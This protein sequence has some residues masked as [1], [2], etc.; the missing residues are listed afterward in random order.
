MGT[1]VIN[2]LI[3]PSFQDIIR[4]EKGGGNSECELGGGE[5]GGGI[6]GAKYLVL[7]FYQSWH[8]N[9]RLFK[10]EAFL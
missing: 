4:V 8:L 9:N 5:G 6:N 10:S 2:S 1:S 7:N 3:S